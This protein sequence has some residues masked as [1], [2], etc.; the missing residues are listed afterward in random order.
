MRFRLPVSRIEVLFREP[1]GAED[2]YLLGAT[3][4]DA[5]LALWVVGA[6]GRPLL[7]EPVPWERLSVTDLD[8]AILAVRKVVLGDTIASTIQCTCGERID[9]AFEVDHYLAQHAP[10]SVN[11]VKP[12]SSAGWWEIEGLDGHFRLPSTADQVAIAGHGSPRAE[13]IRRCFRPSGIGPRSR[14]R[15]ERAMEALAPSLHGN[16]EGVCPACEAVVRIAFDPQRYVLGELRQRAAFVLEEVH[17]IA[18][19]YGWSEPRILALPQG[20]RARYAELV[21]EMGIGG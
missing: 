20:R 2:V 16:L 13:L 14:Q 19:R 15:M 8:A 9:I 5:E 4:G 17:L 7:D 10:R 21:H 3:D 11:K 1:K 6:L 18:S 12:S